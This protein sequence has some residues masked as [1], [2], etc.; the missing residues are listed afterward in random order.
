[1]SLLITLYFLHMYLSIF[2][3]SI[4]LEVWSIP[5]VG[6][7]MLLLDIVDA[8]CWTLSVNRVNRREGGREGVR[9]GGQAKRV[10]LAN[11]DS[12]V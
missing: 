6:P 9:E 7:E 5:R 11:I 2:I 1:M 3:T 10:L 8:Q 12:V 4:I